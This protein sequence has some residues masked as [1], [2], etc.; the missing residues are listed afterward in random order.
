MCALGSLQLTA[1]QRNSRMA[2]SLSHLQ[3]Y[4]EEESGFLPRKLVVKRCQHFEPETKRQNKLWKLETLPP[5]KKSKA[6]HISS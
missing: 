4:H 5:P 2:L 6:I 3:R 1:E